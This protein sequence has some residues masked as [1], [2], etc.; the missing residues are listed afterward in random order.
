MLR[1]WV[2]TL[3]LV[4]VLAWPMSAFALDVADPAPPFEGQTTAGDKIVS[5]EMKGK[6]ALFLVFWATWCPVCK[7]EIP[8]LKAIHETYATKG[9]PLI[10]IDVGVNDSLK[11][12]EKYLEDHKIT[13]PVIF[14]EGS[15]ITKLY[16]IQGTP[17]VVIVDKGGIVRYR[18][19]AIPDD[20]KDHFPALM[21]E[22]GS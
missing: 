3:M 9:M 12:V 15:K 22:P 20:L 1:E 16:G 18:S 21:K 13:Y 14:D 17:T 2:I 7:T 5:A 6:G 11:K 4:A 8:K 19:A 10:A